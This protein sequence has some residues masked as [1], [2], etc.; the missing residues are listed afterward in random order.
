MGKAPWEDGEGVEEVSYVSAA[1]QQVVQSCKPVFSQVKVTVSISKKRFG[2]DLT[3]L[4]TWT[5]VALS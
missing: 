4:E 3:G 5:I 1:Q 2:M